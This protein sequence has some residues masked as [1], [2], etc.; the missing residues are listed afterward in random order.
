MSDYATHH[1]DSVTV[2]ARF[3]PRR[4]WA[5]M[6]LANAV[7]LFLTGLILAYWQ[8]YLARAP[9][10]FLLWGFHAWVLWK[11]Y[12]VVRQLR[13]RS[14]AACWV[15]RGRLVYADVRNISVHLDAVAWVDAYDTPMTWY[16][17]RLRYVRIG[18]KSG[19]VRFIPMALLVESRP[20]LIDRIAELVP[21]TVE[22]DRRDPSDIRRRA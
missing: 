6:A 3:A 1:G 11:S 5:A 7:Y 20:T 22:V 21:D 9:L 14:G 10:C 19:W 13:S 15:Q 2:I 17:M 16:R 12:L 8:D 4:A 18:L